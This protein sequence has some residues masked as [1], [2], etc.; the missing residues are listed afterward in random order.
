VSAPSIGLC[1]ALDSPS[2][3]GRELKLAPR[4]REPCEAIDAGATL[5]AL[6]W[7]RR[8]FKTGVQSVIGL[9][10]CLPRPEFD[11]YVRGGEI[12]R[13]LALATNLK[14]ARQVIA[15]A[16][17]V[18]STSKVLR[19][20]VESRSDLEIRF[21]HGLVFGAMPANAAGDRGRGASCVLLDEFAH[22]FDGDPD[23]PLSAESLLAAVVPSVSQF[24]SLGT[25]VVASTPSGDSNKF[26]ALCDDIVEKPTPTAA[27]FFGKTWEINPRIHEED[28]VE[29][30][31]LLGPE[32]FSQE[33]ECN[34]LSGAGS[35]LN[36]DSI[37]ACVGE[38]GDTEYE[39][40]LEYS[41][42]IDPAMS[43]D[44][45]GCVVLGVER[46]DPSRMVCCQVHGWQG[47]K[48]DT[49]EQ[50]RLR[51][52]ELLNRVVKVCREYHIDEVATDIFKAREIRNRLSEHGI[53][54][55]DVPFT[56]DGR[57]AA[58]TA[59][60]LVIDEKRIDLPREPQL[61]TELRALRV[62]YTSTGQVVEIPRLAGKSHC[63]RAIA[64]MLAIAAREGDAS[65]GEMWG[66]SFVP[67][68]R[69][70]SGSDGGDL[71]GGLFD[72]GFASPLDDPRW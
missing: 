72:G 43:S 13:V 63:D 58:F 52:D 33:Y 71:G 15:S 53:R 60:R 29:E 44:T 3:L 38:G 14:Q 62:K 22:H 61:L 31:R 1:E 17:V 41:L 12:R 45:F 70:P 55:V 32:L 42:G 67:G 9:Y 7:G 24:K 25:L 30:R 27:Y 51:E 28:L 57:R 34:R 21:R 56:G 4:Q 59:L 69:P 8:S 20:M 40:G 19:P 18:I 6:E 48:S 10:H 2:L 50:A 39:S 37:E 16:E 36:A 64:M 68:G 35:F 47:E 23:G 5:V 46:S 26:A 11:D 54:V 66:F 65:S 49:F